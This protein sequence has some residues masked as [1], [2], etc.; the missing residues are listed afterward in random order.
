MNK[1]I[2]L[3][4]CTLFYFNLHAQVKP[5]DRIT[6][7]WLSQN[8]HGKI[9]IYKNGGKFFGKLIWGDKMYAP[10]GKTSLK[11]D[12]NPDQKLKSRDLKD[13]IMLTDF[14]YKDDE[15]TD[16]KI[17]D[18]EAGKTYSCNLTLKNGQLRIRGYILTPMFGRTE[19][20]TR[21]Q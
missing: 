7:V 9:E 19:T 18:P 6:G 10:D 17:Y 14:V 3:A 1:F 5:E 20:W 4:F 8:K 2:L 12:N 21:V 16:G 13:L 15:W 11:D